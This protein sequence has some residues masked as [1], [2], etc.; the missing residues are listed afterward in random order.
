LIGDVKEDHRES[1]SGPPTPL[2]SHA[3]RSAWEHAFVAFACDELNGLFDRIAEAIGRGEPCPPQLKVRLRPIL[4]ALSWAPETVV[5]KTWAIAKAPLDR[6]EDA[7]A[8]ALIL[9]SL[10][11]DDA[12][13]AAWVTA[14]PPSVRQAL[15]AAQ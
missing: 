2:L 3:T 14:C 1:A 10:L 7:F 15:A 11:P 9:S 13:V 8:S 6:P 4:E 12:D 5:R